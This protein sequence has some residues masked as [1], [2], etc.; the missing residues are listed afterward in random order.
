MKYLSINATNTCEVGMHLRDRPGGGPVSARVDGQP[1]YDDWF[2]T[3]SFVVFWYLILLMHD[4]RDLFRHEDFCDNITS[5]EN[6][7]CM[8]GYLS[9]TENVIL[10]P[11]G[12]AQLKL[13]TQMPKQVLV[14]FS[15]Q[16]MFRRQRGVA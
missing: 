11:I 12:Q 6:A 7:S 16:K 9:D 8:H 1:V 2:V 5:M 4:R 15:L 13:A 10:N 3:V 14:C